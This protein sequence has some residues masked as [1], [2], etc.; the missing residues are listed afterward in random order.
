MWRLASILPI[1]RNHKPKPG[2]PDLV[3]WVCRSSCETASWTSLP[4]GC[5]FDLVFVTLDFYVDVVSWTKLVSVSCRTHVKFIH[6][7][8]RP[9]PPL[10][11]GLCVQSLRSKLTEIRGDLPSNKNPLYSVIQRSRQHTITGTSTSIFVVTG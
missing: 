1:N 6:H 4:V 10:Q 11:L 7:V 2:Q 3:F 9:S 5:L 8:I